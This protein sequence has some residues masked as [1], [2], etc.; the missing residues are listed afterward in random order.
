M[1]EVNAADIGA[2]EVRDENSPIKLAETFDKAATTA[3]KRINRNVKENEQ[4]VPLTSIG[5]QARDLVEGDIVREG[6][7]TA[8]QGRIRTAMKR[9]IDKYADA[10]RAYA[11][12]PSKFQG[13]DPTNSLEIF[14][15]QER[16]T[17]DNPGLDNKFIKDVDPY[18]FADLMNTVQAEV[19]ADKDDAKAEFSIMS[20]KWKKILER[21]R[22]NPKYNMGG[23]DSERD[24]GHTQFTWWMTQVYADN[25]TA[26]RLYN[27]N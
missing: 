24:D 5:G 20:K 8:N 16:I 15:R 26:E 3:F 11:D 12:D 22:Q 9:A 27:D 1:V 2:R 4:L 23:F 10:M 19:D 14:Y 17:V 21:K 7:D 13:R 25:P 18:L 6:A